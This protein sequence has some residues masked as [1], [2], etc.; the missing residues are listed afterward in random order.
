M[1]I[2]L[3]LTSPPCPLPESDLLSIPSGCLQPTLAAALFSH[4][5]QHTA[6][7]PSSLYVVLPPHSVLPHVTS[8]RTV[9]YRAASVPAFALCPPCAAL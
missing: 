2:I 6:R 1:P 9:T 5:N 4:T 3:P 8:T 7:T